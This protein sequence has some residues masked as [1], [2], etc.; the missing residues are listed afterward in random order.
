MPD[1]APFRAFH[2]SDRY[3]PFIKRLVCPPYD[4]ISPAGRATLVHR[5]PRNFV[6]VELPAGDPRK[7]YRQSTAIWGKWLDDG[8]LVRDPEPAFYVYEA[9]FTSALTGRPLARRG[10]FAALKLVPWGKG[11]HPHEKTLPTHKADRLELF[12]TLGVQTSPIQCLAEDRAG[13][14]ADLIDRQA[15]GRPWVSYTDE[16]GVSHRLWRWAPDKGAAALVRLA[17]RSRFAIADGHHRYETSRAFSALVRGRR[18][19]RPACDYVMTYFSPSS[20]PALEI[21]PTHRA[22]G[23]DKKKFVNLEKWGRLTPVAGLQALE[24]LIK[25]RDRSRAVGVYREGKFYRYEF[26]AVPPTIKG[27]IHA[28]LAV[29][30]LHAG[31]LKGLGKEDFFFTREPSEAVAEARRS[32]GWAFFPGPNTVDEVVKVSLAGKVMPPKSTYFTPKLPSGLVS[33]ALRGE[34]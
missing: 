1:I 8:V 27:T 33:R 19:N 2:Y 12:K 15:K 7:R 31:A 30:C 28:R 17:A 22:V 13:K 24:P 26:T 21:W 20:D 29:A 11:V 5:H 10:V 9:R 3:L 25:G 23:W 16:A 34:L 6:Q 4:V 14:M 18:E 32:K